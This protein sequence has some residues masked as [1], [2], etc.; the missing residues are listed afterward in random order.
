MPAFD[1][2]TRLSPEALHQPKSFETLEHHVADQVHAHGPEVR[3]LS[4]YALLGPW[5]YMD[6]IDVPDME[7]AT[8]VSVLVRSFGH[9]STE[10]WPALPWP[11]FK[12]V[13]RSLSARFERVT[14]LRCQHRHCAGT[15]RCAEHQQELSHV[16]TSETG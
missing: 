6:V 15:Q 9:A 12:G 14:P 10:I 5:D 8:R 13:L 3:W 4:G 2:L 1:L 16:L 7:Y 11:D